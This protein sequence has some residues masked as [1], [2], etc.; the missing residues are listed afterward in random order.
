MTYKATVATDLMKNWASASAFSNH[1][2]SVA[3]DNDGEP[4]IF[5]IGNDDKFFVVTR[6][7]GGKTGWRQQDLLHGLDPT[8]AAAAFQVSQDHT[9]QILIVVAAHA[10]GQT[11]AARLYVSPLLTPGAAL[12]WGRIAWTERQFVGG[13]KEVTR[14]IMGAADRGAPL[15]LAAVKEAGEAR[16]YHVNVDTA[17]TSWSTRLHDLPE[18]ARV[19]QDLS[20]GQVNRQQVAF[21]LYDI[22]QGQTLAWET[23]VDPNKEKPVYG[24]LVLPTG[25]TA[26]CIAVLP[27]R[28]TASDDIYVAGDWGISVHAKGSLIGQPLRVSRDGE[29]LVDMTK[30]IGTPTRLLAVDDDDAIALWVL[31]KEQELHY[32]YRPRKDDRPWRGP[33]ALAKGVKEIA[34]FRNQKRRTNAI[35]IVKN[36]NSLEYHTQDP[37]TRRWEAVPIMLP[38]TGQVVDFLCYTTQIR[39][40]DAKGAPVPKEKVKLRGGEWVQVTVNGTTHVLD[41]KVDITVET[42][43]QGRL[44]LIQPVSGLGVT[45]YTIE[46]ERLPK[47]LHVEPG[48]TVLAKLSKLKS[49]ADLD[50]LKARDGTTLADK[51]PENQ[52]ENA[53]LMLGQLASDATRMKAKDDAPAA[54]AAGPDAISEPASEG[55]TIDLSGTSPTLSEGAIETGPQSYYS[56]GEFFDDAGSVLAAIGSGLVKGAKMSLKLVGDAMELVVSLAGKILKF[57]LKTIG[58][59][60]KGINSLIKELTGVDLIDELIEFLGDLLPWEDILV[61]HDVITN[62]VNLGFDAGQ[63]LMAD[64]RGESDKFFDGIVDDIRKFGEEKFGTSLKLGGGRAALGHGDQADAVEDNPGYNFV[65]YHLENSMGGKGSKEP[66]TAKKEDADFLTATWNDVVALGEELWADLVKLV[67]EVQGSLAADVSIGDLLGRV[68]VLLASGVIGVVKRVVALLLDSVRRF[69]GLVQGSLNAEI[70]VPFLSPLYKKHTGH[71]LTVLRAIAF[72]IGLPVTLLVKLVSGEAPFPFVEV[73]ASAFA[74]STTGNSELSSDPKYAGKARKPKTFGMET[75]AAEGAT[76]VLGG[77]F[78]AYKFFTTTERV[79]KLVST[80]FETLMHGVDMLLHSVRWI[81]F[82]VSV[83]QQM[84][85]VVFMFI[86]PEDFIVW[87]AIR[88]AAGFVGLLGDY[89]STSI[90]TTQLSAQIN[91]DAAQLGR[92]SPGTL[93]ASKETMHGF[94]T[95]GSMF[96]LIGKAVELIAAIPVAIQ[97]IIRHGKTDGGTLMVVTD[98]VGL[99]VLGG[100]TGAVYLARSPEPSTNA[101]GKALGLA[102]MGITLVGAIAPWVGKGVTSKD[103]LMEPI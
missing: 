62:L 38:D 77:V 37:E 79:A 60:L 61:T 71:E 68:A 99:L 36:N 40:R 92:L 83:I 22:G 8:L 31:N 59:V 89:Q 87:R 26:A 23:V 18:H 76:A 34:V 39:L 56:V 33:L 42:D 7:H 35:F 24:R 72:V 44:T 70:D 3:Q 10:A 80:T 41:P 25:G 13:G 30:A 73:G 95:K 2:F 97:W 101:A 57:W 58:S 21:A 103:H 46:H 49:A 55:W 29:D 11:G 17:D 75:V 102:C 90:A 19:F 74:A 82:G 15:V 12:D 54:F 47:L 4:L 9:G 69:I 93:A 65:T 51:I 27:G 94:D 91:V 53:A 6:E 63:K 16:H 14:I 96:K 100:E 1:R 84:C 81:A 88:F 20:T 85:K 67:Q 78:I 52:R 48:D 45:S 64:A 28:G 86:I 98:V 5:S 43:H 50:T 32:L 66:A